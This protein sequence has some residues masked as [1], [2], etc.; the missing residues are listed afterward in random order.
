M[1]IEK[2]QDWLA[3]AQLK[4]KE[5]KKWMNTNRY[6]ETLNRGLLHTWMQRPFGNKKK[7]K[8][9]HDGIIINRFNYK[10]PL[11]SDSNNNATRKL[12]FYQIAPWLYCESKI[13]INWFKKA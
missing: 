13:I 9:V 3:C 1:N 7:E 10:K 4:K 12:N 6:K 2:L 8:S 11:F 5:R